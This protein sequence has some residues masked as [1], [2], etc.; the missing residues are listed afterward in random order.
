[1]T[2]SKEFRDDLIKAYRSLN[3]DHEAL[4]AL[5][6]MQEGP[7]IIYEPN[8]MDLVMTKDRMRG[9]PVMVSAEMQEEFKK[10]IL[11]LGIEPDTD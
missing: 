2:D 3:P 7:N 8:L 5:R 9:G 4:S 10:I 6:R 11:G 1:M